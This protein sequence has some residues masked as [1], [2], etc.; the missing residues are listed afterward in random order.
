M[1]R[2][3]S[4]R[5]LRRVLNLW[6]PYLFSGIHVRS[7]ADD[8]RSAEVELRLRWW[9]RNYVGTHYGGNLFSMTDPFWM[10]L[11]LHALGRDYLV[12]DQT[13]EIHFLKPG[14]GTV[15]AVFRLDDTALEEIRAATADGGKHLRWFENAIVDDAGETVAKVRKRLYIRRKPGRRP[16]PDTAAG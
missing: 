16:T 12:W 7:I 10:L 8:W 3:L 2:E 1:K 14:R 5:A 6:P 13:G 4:P 11:A 9:N 15:R